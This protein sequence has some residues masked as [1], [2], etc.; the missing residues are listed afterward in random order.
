MKN[1]PKGF[2]LK[3][4]FCEERQS[5]YD[6]KK[7]LKLM[8]SPEIEE[9]RFS[10]STTDPPTEFGWTAGRRQ[11]SH[12]PGNHRKAQKHGRSYRSCTERHAS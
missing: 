4:Y 9:L 6:Y 2:L 1:S 11:F 3:A 8:K 7:E 12:Q 10:G 5:Y